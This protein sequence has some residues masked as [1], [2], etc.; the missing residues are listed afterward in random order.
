MAGGGERAQ[1]CQCESMVKDH[2]PRDHNC[3]TKKNPQFYPGDILNRYSA[4]INCTTDDCKFLKNKPYKVCDNLHCYIKETM[5]PINLKKEI[6]KA[7]KEEAAQKYQRSKSL[8]STADIH[9][10][11]DDATD[12]DTNNGAADRN[13]AAGMDTDDM[14][15]R[16][17]NPAYIPSDIV[18]ANNSSTDTGGTDSILMP[19]PA[20]LVS[21]PPK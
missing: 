16:L 11:D 12:T 18:G 4:T 8:Q 10:T 5:G 1:Y 6:E 3:N 2:V 20:Y 17:H 21:P 19:T 13:D 15:T 14:A 7:Q 9:S